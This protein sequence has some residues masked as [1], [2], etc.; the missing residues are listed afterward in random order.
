MTGGQEWFDAFVAQGSDWTQARL[1]SLPDVVAADVPPGVWE[2]SRAVGSI[3]KAHT[4]AI[5]M[6][7]YVNRA[8]RAVV[9]RTGP[10][11]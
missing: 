4:T 3:V 11:P 6:H 10:Q 1:P 7:V 2:G 8:A 5:F 9:V